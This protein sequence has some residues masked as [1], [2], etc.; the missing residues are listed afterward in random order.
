M[1]MPDY[2]PFLA[3]LSDLFA[4]TWERAGGTAFR[5]HHSVQVAHLCRRLA[6]EFEIQPDEMDCLILAALFHDVA[7]HRRAVYK[8]LLRASHAEEKQFGY[9]THE[10]QSAKMASELLVKHR[11]PEQIASVADIIRNHPRPTQLLECIL[12]DADEL[13]EMGYMNLWKMFTY[14]QGAGRDVADTLRY[15]QQEDRTRQ[16]SKVNILSLSQSKKM[17]ATRI[18]E[19]DAIAE[20]LQEELTLTFI[21]EGTP[22]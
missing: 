5:Y 13:S 20:R 12:H 9:G 10:G 15:W 16:M 19:I 4:P 17:A 1:A 22:L 3:T 8:G 6:T 21:P 7:K 11:S 2:G 14:S 18:S